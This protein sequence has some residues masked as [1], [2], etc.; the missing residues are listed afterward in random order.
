MRD[1]E[2]TRDQLLA[3]LGA[4]RAQVGVQ[5]S[6]AFGTSPTALP[7]MQILASAPVGFALYD[8]ELRYLFINE[9]LAVINGIPVADHIGRTVSEVL[10]ELALWWSPI[11]RQ[12]QDSRKSV[13][14]VEISGATSAPPGEI[15]YWIVNAYPVNFQDGD[16][17]GV[18]VF[19]QDITARKRVEQAL[20]ASEERYH[21]VVED[22]NELICRYLPDGRLSFV[23]EAYLRYYGLLREEAL[24]NNFVPNIPQSDQ[25][26]I[27]K[28]LRSLSPDHPSINFTHRILLPGDEVRWQEWTHRAIYSPPGELAEFQAVGS[29]ITTRKQAEAQLIE[30]KDRAEAANI[31]KSDFLA[32][33][34]HELTTPLNAV[35][36]FSEVLLD[37]FF[38]E[39]N[40]KQ[41]EYV[42]A[43]R[44]SGLR[45]LS[46]LTDI[47]QLTKLDAGDE[48]LDLAPVSPAALLSVVLEMN[49]EKA[50]RHNITLDFDLG[51]DMEQ[52]TLLDGVKFRQV[53]FALLSN[54][55][56]F[57]PDNGQVRIEGRRVKKNGA[58]ILEV[59]VQ[60]SGPGIP[61]A[62]APNLFTPFS[63]LERPY[64]KVHQG[65]GLGLALARRLA[66]LQ[67]GDIELADSSAKGNR[68][69]FRLPVRDE[70]PDAPTA[71]R[72]PPLEKHT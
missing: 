65:V 47:L 19:V 53:L 24:G 23:N 68:L 13:L 4:L 60:D 11:Y 41:D 33:M 58:E 57:T 8:S 18:G 70:A 50:L 25:E 26:T 34:R 67:G 17:P 38:G 30:L 7:F 59:S 36:G 56:K 27:Q 6:C 48:A 44:E 31:A 64:T 45:L 42:N 10:P 61:E 63:Q 55:V 46:L 9:T 49:R 69:V 71:D 62:F 39:L 32:N 15:R 14:N 22:Q 3:E 5:K 29:D 72:E 35:I 1:S 2:K 28:H 12:V 21:R 37:R 52:A 20:S 66:R 54:A 16:V 51:P 43:I 40:A